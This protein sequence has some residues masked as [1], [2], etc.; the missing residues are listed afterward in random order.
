MAVRQ[1]NF[2]K[3]L[4]SILLIEEEYYFEDN[5]FSDVEEEYNDL[6]IEELKELIENWCDY[7]CYYYDNGIPCPTDGHCFRV[8]IG[9]KK[10]ITKKK[11]KND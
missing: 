1:K 5:G 6:E 4:Q 8:L 11:I 10:Q 3:K 9:I 2:H 7:E